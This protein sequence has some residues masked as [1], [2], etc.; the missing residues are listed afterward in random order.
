M[1]LYLDRL[2]KESFLQMES[3]G[4]DQTP[5]GD[6]DALCCICSNGDCTDTDMIIF[7]EVCNIAVIYS[8]SNAL[9]KLIK[10]I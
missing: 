9:E 8:F 3:A 7:C 2:E 4:V 10:C 6:D 5:V 1:E